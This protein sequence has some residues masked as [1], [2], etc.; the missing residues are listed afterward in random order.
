[1]GCFGNNAM[2]HA[3][4]IHHKILSIFMFKYTCLNSE[5]ELV[6]FKP[7]KSATKSEI[8]LCLTW[9]LFCFFFIELEAEA[10]VLEP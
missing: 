7:F 2:Q 4:S 3:N 10:T 1:M 6:M 8:K 9:L 5:V